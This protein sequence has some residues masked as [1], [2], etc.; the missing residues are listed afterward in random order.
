MASVWLCVAAA[1]FLIALSKSRQFAQDAR[2]P[3]IGQSEMRF[4][5]GG[6][7]MLLDHLDTTT[8][9]WL[10]AAVQGFGLAAAL[11]SRVS[12]GS[13]FQAWFQGLFLVC[14]LLTGASTMVA[15]QLGGGYWLVSAATL[16][17]MVL[18]AVCDFHNDG[19]A[20][21]LWS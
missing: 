1:R 5:K 14:L 20:Y 16:G 2:L 19:R 4:Q 21:T 18:V 13:V 8:V 7:R 6:W 3:Q 10:F 15:P 12:E 17:M 11:L 9:I